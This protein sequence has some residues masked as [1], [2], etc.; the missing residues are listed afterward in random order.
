MTL[1][2]QFGGRGRGEGKD[3]SLPSERDLVRLARR[4]RV[5]KEVRAHLETW[6]GQDL[7]RYCES[8][9]TLSEAEPNRPPR[10]DAQ[11]NEEI[12]GV[13]TREGFALAHT[14]PQWGFALTQFYELVIQAS[15]K[16]NVRA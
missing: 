6:L 15:F 7:L 1:L 9:K 3:S 16:A 13:F 10:Q 12:I 8:Q 4:V 11:K 2:E 5:N 14:D